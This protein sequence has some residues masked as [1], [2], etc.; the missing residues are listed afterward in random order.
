MHARASMQLRLACMRIR[1]AHVIR[2]PQHAHTAPECIHTTLAHRRA[3]PAKLHRHGWGG[4]CHYHSHL[5]LFGVAGRGL[6]LAFLPSAQNPGSQLCGT[7]SCCWLTASTRHS[8][9]LSAWDSVS[10]CGWQSGCLWVWGSV[11]SVDGSRCVLYHTT[12]VSS[13][14]PPSCSNDGVSKSHKLPLST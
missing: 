12:S 3:L 7:H 9:C 8:G 13:K 14:N 4:T 6:C 2:C 11:S 10:N 5:F 1:H